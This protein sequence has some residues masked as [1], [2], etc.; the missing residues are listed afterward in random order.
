MKYSWLTGAVG[1]LLTA[2]LTFYALQLEQKLALESAHLRLN[3][4]LD[5]VEK[6]MIVS[7]SVLEQMFLGLQQYVEVIEQVPN[8][9]ESAL[10]RAMDT[11][12][13][14]NSYMVSLVVTDS[15]GDILYWTNSGTRPNLSERPFF[16][17]HTSAL[18]EGTYFS[19][20]LPSIMSPGQWILGASK[21]LR[22]P[23]GSL[24][25]VLIAI[26]DTR[27]LFSTVENVARDPAL[28]LAILAPN[29]AMYA[30]SADH[31]DVVGSARPELLEGWQP[32]QTQKDIAVPRIVDGQKH[33]VMMRSL[34][35]YQLIIRA[36]APLGALSAQG[37]SRFLLLIAS[38]SV[39]GLILL[40]QLSAV[41]RLQR[42]KKELQER[43]SKEEQCDP[44]TGL[45]LWLSAKDEQTPIM[46]T[47]PP[48][49]VMIV[50][51]D[52]YSQLVTEFG[53]E[54]GNLLVVHSAQ[55]V[56]T[57]LPA[58]ARVSRY[59]CS[60]FILVLSETDQPQAL[61]AAEQLRAT[62]ATAVGTEQTPQMKL[63]VSVGVTQV[64]SDEA[65]FAAAVKRATTALT[66][67][68]SRG[69]NQVCWLA[70]RESWLEQRDS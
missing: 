6:E 59:L 46:N 45:P 7:L 25:R 5:R 55:I 48:L 12:V 34:E 47:D 21:A 41:L 40:W 38:G 51:I 70:A 35:E 62:L 32:T 39:V 56:A 37:P 65:D 54:A 53:E 10:R 15:S 64:E 67:A 20:P 58:M 69:G 66:T 60:K 61:A 68:T 27:R 42:N 14:D 52:G 33:L 23:D 49:V 8:R 9:D 24:H 13:L 3:E 43:L 36:Q 2:F 28:T 17:A 19:E 18:I 11:L 29:G 26:L 4:T 50:G 16:S 22:Y 30:H 57:W 44:L 31:H 1:L 63:S